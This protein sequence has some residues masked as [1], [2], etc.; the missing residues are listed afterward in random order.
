MVYT[1]SR[2][3]QPGH[4]RKSCSNLIVEVCLSNYAGCLDDSVIRVA[5]RKHGKFNIHR[6]SNEALGPPDGPPSYTTTSKQEREERKPRKPLKE[7]SRGIN[8]TSPHPHITSTKLKHMEGAPPASILPCK[9][10]EYY[11]HGADRS[12]TSSIH[13]NR[14]F[15]TTQP[16]PPRSTPLRHELAGDSTTPK[17][18]EEG[19]GSLPTSERRRDEER[20]EKRRKRRLPGLRPQN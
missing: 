15:T 4:N 18:S 12:K 19:G 8:A 16:P 11:E 13:T 3:K 2:C 5:Q 7:G 1:C 20:K 14:A 6:S 17:L 10:Q 9:P